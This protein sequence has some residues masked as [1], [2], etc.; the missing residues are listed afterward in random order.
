MTNLSG[1]KVQFHHDHGLTRDGEGR[2][3]PGF[4]RPHHPELGGAAE[5]PAHRKEPLM[6]CSS[7]PRPS[8]SWALTLGASLAAVLSGIGLGLRR[9]IAEYQTRH[10]LM[11]LDDTL[12]KDIGLSR[13]DI[14]AVVHRTGRD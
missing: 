11:K 13:S 2:L 4:R 8:N 7:H 1:A 5:V 6:W 14:E 12:L 9:W 3:D 10:A